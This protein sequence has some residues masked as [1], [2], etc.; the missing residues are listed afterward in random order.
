VSPEVS[1]LIPSY[2]YAR[3]LDEAIGSV[4]G[5][6]FQ[7]FEIVA[8][9]DGSKDG[10]YEKL[11]AW[12]ARCPGKIIAFRHPSGRNEGLCETY[13]A[14]FRASSGAIIAFLEA[15]DCW[16]PENLE[17][18]VRVLKE[19]P[20]VGVVFSRYR[21]FGSRGESFYWRLYEWANA[22][23]MPRNRSFDLSVEFARRNPV[24]SFSHFVVRRRDLELILSFKSPS[25][26]FDWWVLAHLSLHRR[27]WWIDQVL[28]FWRIHPGSAGYGPVT[29]KMLRK[30]R[31]F[32]LVLYRSLE[33]ERGEPLEGSMRSAARKT[34][35]F[36]E[37]ARGQKRGWIFSAYLFHPITALRFTVFLVLR[38]LLFE[39][40]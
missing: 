17:R 22:R 2:N 5:Q 23:S 28:C 13:R 14:A 21:P 31:G 7:D 38:R 32:L 15:D 37:G 9:D 25:F 30:L 16:A 4:L 20:D 6:T 29:R 8:V 18:K 12:Q 26:N 24:A 33:R 19:N 34:L 36:L 10:S 27:F 11:L 40:D 39:S 3:Y 35:R 1:V